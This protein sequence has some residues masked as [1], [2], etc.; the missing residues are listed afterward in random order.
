MS[1]N[2][3]LVVV[4]LPGLE[5][6]GSCRTASMQAV[7]EGRR[8]QGQGIVQQPRCNAQLREGPQV[9]VSPCCGQGSSVLV[10][11]PRMQTRSPFP[12]W[13][14]RERAGVKPPDVVGVS[15]L[16]CPGGRELCQAADK[17]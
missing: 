17:A 12:V 14:G 11:M 16:L 10:T 9:P 5:V 2:E 13:E 6:E 1:P 4:Y 15:Y 7:G 8:E 3:L